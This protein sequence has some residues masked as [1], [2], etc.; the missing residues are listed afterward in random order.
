VSLNEKE[1]GFPQGLRVM[2]NS[3]GHGNL[4]LHISSTFDS[5]QIREGQLHTLTAVEVKIT[6]SFQLVE[7]ICNKFL[8]SSDL[9]AAS[10]NGRNTS[11]H[12]FTQ[13]WPF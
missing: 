12:F 5:L 10:R 4:I 13:G 1:R 2:S 7:Y 9:L 11:L 3:D 8:R 6:T